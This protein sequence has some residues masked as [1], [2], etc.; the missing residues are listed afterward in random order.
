MNAQET[1]MVQLNSK[2]LLTATAEDT[3]ANVVKLKD[4][5]KGSLLVTYKEPQ[6]EG[7]SRTLMI[8]DEGDNQLLTKTGQSVAVSTATLKSWAKKGNT[9]KVYTVQQSLNPKMA[10]RVRRVHLC[11]L[12]FE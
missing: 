1:W 4:L 2:V 7:W 6:K 5:K 11:T 10:I 9:L 8:Y 12:M 3:V